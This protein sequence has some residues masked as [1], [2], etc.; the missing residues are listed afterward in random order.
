MSYLGIA[1]AAADPTLRARVTG[2]IAQ[3]GAPGN[4]QE[5]CNQIIWQCCGEPGW[6]AAWTSA[7]EAE[8]AKPPEERNPDIGGNPA[9][10]PDAWILTAVQKHLGLLVAGQQPAGDV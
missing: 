2:C 1:Q 3:E 10:I 8:K 9:V 4:P 6:G 7:L 5:L